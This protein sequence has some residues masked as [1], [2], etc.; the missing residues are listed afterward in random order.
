MNRIATG[1]LVT[2]A[3]L[4]VAVLGA[5]VGST[6]ASFAALPQVAA[7]PRDNP[8]T[9]ERVALGRLLFWDPILSGDRDVACGSCHHPRFG[10]AENRD[11]SIGV[12]G[13]GLGDRRRFAQGSKVP[14]VKRNSQT[15]LNV[16]F[17]G[18]DESGRHAPATAPMFWDVRA[19][20]LEE[21]ALVPMKTLEEMRGTAYSEDKAVDAVV[22]RLAALPEYRKLFAG[23]F[24]AGQGVTSTNLARALAAFQRSLTANRSPFDRYM[25]GE[26]D[27]MN[28]SQQRGM[29]R[30]ERIG[31][32]NCHTGPMFSDFKLHVLGVPDN[33]KLPASDAG[34]EKRYAF[35]TAS[36]R[37]LAFTAP[38]MHSGVFATLEDVLDFYD[39]VD[40]RR[41]RDRN[42]NVS[43]DQLDPLLRRLRGVDDD[44]EDLLAFLRSL[45]DESFD[46]TIPD[47]VPS[48]LPVGG[49]IQ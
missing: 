26:T 25:R 20:S 8:T 6:Q 29:R 32:G 42:V 16:G 31:C 13:V 9:P 39:D 49:R 36:L 46:R 18:I 4:G 19:S 22:A 38:Y 40:D 48:G 15:I 35:R 17:N 28:A 37:N 47:R 30:F 1:L 27:A 12:S 43:R 23:A 3:G 5:A 41:G 45:S 21:Q 44:D 7:A 33:P 10:Y 24:G 34:A 11:L 14:F 2:A